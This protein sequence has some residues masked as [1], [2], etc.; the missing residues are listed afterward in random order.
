MTTKKKL[1]F[2]LAMALLP[3]ASVCVSALPVGVQLQVRIENR[4]DGSLITFKDE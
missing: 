2:S 1:L 4:G 3:F